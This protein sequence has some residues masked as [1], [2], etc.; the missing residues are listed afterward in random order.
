M[1][2]LLLHNKAEVMGPRAGFTSVILT[3]Q[4][5][6]IGGTLVKDSHDKELVKA[7]FNQ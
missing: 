3:A 5:A 4:E 6:V 2:F 7:H 1:S